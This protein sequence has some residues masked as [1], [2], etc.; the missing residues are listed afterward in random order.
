MIYTKSFSFS[1]KKAVIILLVSHIALLSVC[2][3]YKLIFD[4]TAGEA[5]S[6]KFF[7]AFGVRCMGCGGSRSLMAL[8]EFNLIKSFLLYPPILISCVFIL[9]V[10]IRAIKAVYLNTAAPIK[11]FKAAWTVVIPASIVL[12]FLVRLI[13]MLFFKTDLVA[14]AAAL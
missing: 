11:R 12:T 3:I 5:F 7:S 14:Q 6:C 10:D 4:V 13:A 2:L 8:L 1:R 9:D